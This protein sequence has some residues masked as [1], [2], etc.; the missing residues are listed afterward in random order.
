MKLAHQTVYLSKYHWRASMV[1][2][3]LIIKKGFLCQV[4]SGTKSFHGIHGSQLPLD[5]IDIEVVKQYI[6]RTF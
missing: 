5:G 4:H 6:F 1:T 2:A 3:L